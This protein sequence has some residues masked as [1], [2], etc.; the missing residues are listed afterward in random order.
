MMLARICFKLWVNLNTVMNNKSNDLE[1][2]LRYGSVAVK[3]GRVATFYEQGP[4]FRSS[5]R[6]ENAVEIDLH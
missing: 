1:K 6:E 5:L 2:L 4:Q 3:R